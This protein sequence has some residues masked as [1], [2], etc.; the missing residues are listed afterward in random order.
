MSETFAED[1]TK[2]A[3]DQFQYTDGRDLSLTSREDARRKL[4][5][6]MEKF[7]N[8]GGAIKQIDSDVRADPPRKPESNYGSRPI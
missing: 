3:P 1:N 8:S 4:Q 6:D 5:E 2:V 7:L